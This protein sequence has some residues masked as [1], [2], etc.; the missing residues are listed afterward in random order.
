MITTTNFGLKTYQSSDLFNPLTV[1][2]VNMETIDTNMKTIDNKTIGRATELVSQGVHAITLLDTDAKVFRFVATAN[3]TAGETFTINGIQSN[4]YTPSGSAL[5]TDAYVTGSVVIGSLN[6]DNSAIT[7]YLSGS[8]TAD[9]SLRLGGELP[10]YYATNSDLSDTKTDVTNLKNL[11]GNTSIVGIGDGT[12]TGA[13]SSLNEDI[14]GLKFRIH[15]GNAQYSIDNG[16]TWKNFNEVS[17]IVDVSTGASTYPSYT[18]TNPKNTSITVECRNIT[19]TSNIDNGDA[20]LSIRVNGVQ[21]TRVG[22][23]TPVNQTYVIPANGTLQLYGDI[24]NPYA[25]SGVSQSISGTL[26]IY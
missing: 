10:E 11:T 8:A 22:R 14:G 24:D 1:E 6:A 17:Q 12:M 16:V 25:H 3:Y 9:N 4:A 15:Q 7:F 21:E 13:I 2:N 5:T 18:Y 20:K 19:L 26:Y 23:N